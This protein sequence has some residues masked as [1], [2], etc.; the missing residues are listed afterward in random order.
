MCLASRYSSRPAR[1]ELAP[2]PR[3]LVAAPLGL[4]QVGVVVVDPD[5]P[6]AETRRD[7]LGPARIGRPDRAGQA[8]RRVV[9]EGDRLLLGREPLDRSGP[10]RT[11]P[12]GRC[13]SSLRDVGE[14]RRAVVEAG[15]EL[16]LGR[17]AAAGDQPRA[18]GDRARR[19]SASTL[20]RCSAVMSAPVSV[21]VVGAVTRAGSA[22]RARRPPPRTGRR[23]C[24]GR[25]PGSRPSRPARN[26]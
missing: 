8:V 4:G 14:D 21:R 12:R 26:G 22:R 9:A 19:R 3:L 17:P 1:A 20:A 2:D 25:S 10:D 15:L 11:P 24:P 13:A 23:S 6:V 16:G 5:R 18:L 7:A